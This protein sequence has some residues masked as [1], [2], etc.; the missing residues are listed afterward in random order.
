MDI[1]PQKLITNPLSLGVVGALISLRLAPGNSWL[2]RF[3]NVAIGSAFAIVGAPAAW[4]GFGLKS[5]SML[6]FLSFVIGMFGLSL[7]AAI[8]QGLRELKVG[9]ILTGW[10]SRR[11]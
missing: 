10:L 7:A 4:E 6:G 3:S 1:D 8:M 9:D 2:E 11:G 5:M